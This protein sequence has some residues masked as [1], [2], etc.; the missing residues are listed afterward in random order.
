MTG[1]EKVETFLTIRHYKAASSFGGAAMN[2]PRASCTAGKLGLPLGPHANTKQDALVVLGTS[3]VIAI[4]W[5]LSVLVLLLIL[6]LN[7]TVSV[8]LM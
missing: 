8:L 5:K 1:T 6:T 3:F 4:L 2:V 7:R